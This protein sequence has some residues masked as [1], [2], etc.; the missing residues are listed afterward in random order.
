MEN[1]L[2]SGVIACHSYWK[3]GR[4]Q[5]HLCSLT[6]FRLFLSSSG[7]CSWGLPLCVCVC[8]CYVTSSLHC[9]SCFQRFPSLCRAEYGLWES[10]GLQK[11]AHANH[12]SFRNHRKRSAASSLPS[13]SPAAASI[14]AK[15]FTHLSPSELQSH[16]FTSDTHVLIVLI[17]VDGFVW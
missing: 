9:L 12:L 11:G 15:S 5:P 13:R 10:G 4:A 17:M 6:A 14:S 16:I 3:P 7:G 8:V 2:S 1:T